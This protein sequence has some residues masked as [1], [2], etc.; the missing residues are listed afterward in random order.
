MI[1]L[2]LHFCSNEGTG[3]SRL[4]LASADTPYRTAGCATGSIESPSRRGFV[5][6]QDF[7]TPIQETTASIILGSKEIRLTYTIRFWFVCLFY[8]PPFFGRGMSFFS[9]K[10]PETTRP[11]GAAAVAVG[12]AKA[13]WMGFERLDVQ[14]STLSAPVGG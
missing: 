4:Q 1:C 9:P 12:L 10:R 11:V 8:L 6:F 2:P 7:Q 5:I 3:Q 13:I 14:S